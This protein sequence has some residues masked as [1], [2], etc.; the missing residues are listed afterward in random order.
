ML[1]G[2][3]WAALIATLLRLG[4]MIA[5]TEPRIELEDDDIDL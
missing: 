3:L 5:G 4:M 1:D 2:L